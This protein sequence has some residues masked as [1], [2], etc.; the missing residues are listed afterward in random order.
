M[1]Q[2]CLKHKE[3]QQKYYHKDEYEYSGGACD[4]CKRLE[5][6]QFEKDKLD[7]GER[8]WTVVTRCGYGSSVE[9]NMGDVCESYP[10]FFWTHA[11]RFMETDGFGT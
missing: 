5:L 11:G 7:R 3:V 4:W 1:K 8:V 6:V 10:G 9:E 2:I